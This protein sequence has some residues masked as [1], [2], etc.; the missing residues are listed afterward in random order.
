[1]FDSGWTNHGFGMPNPN[2][3]TIL[4]REREDLNEFSF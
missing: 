3:F 1:M 4:S 2:R